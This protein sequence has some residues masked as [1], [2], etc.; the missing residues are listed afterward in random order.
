MNNTTEP[1]PSVAPEE[2]VGEVA[3]ACVILGLSFLVGAPGN[4]LVIWT[5]LRHVKQ[6][7]HT[8]VLILHLAAADLLVLITLPI[9][10]YSLA[11]TWVFGV[12]LCKTLG[13]VINACMYSS[14]FFI[15]LMSVERYLAICRPFVMMRWK[16]KSTVNR[17]LLLFWLLAFLLGMPALSGTTGETNGTEQCLYREYTS[18]TQEIMFLCMEILVGFVIPFTVLSVCYSL[19][20]VQLKKMRFNSKQKSMVLIHAVVIAFTVCW[21]PYHIINIINLDCRLGSDI[22]HECLPQSVTLGSGALA[23][24]S[25]SVN[26]VLY[27]F[28]SRSF[29][30]NMEDSKLVR[31]FREVTAQTNKLMDLSAQQ[32]TNQGTA[33][34]QQE[35]VCI[36][37]RNVR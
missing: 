22:G 3:V 35:L 9:W 26:P 17:C 18:K 6:R 11:D 1:S 29:R 13:Y 5:I 10:I 27:A 31:L 19:V 30:G 36:H 15:T 12:A 34:T 24:I 14:I 32:A 16:T 33:H 20:A 28:L 8:V 21:L 37:T 25:S 4:L 23:F 2:F 7:S